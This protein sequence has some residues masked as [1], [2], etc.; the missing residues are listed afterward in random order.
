[1]NTNSRRWM[2]AGI[3]ILAAIVLVIGTI[4]ISRVFFS[5]TAAMSWGPGRRFGLPVTG[6]FESNGERI[7]FTGTSSTGPAISAQFPG[8]HSMP[9]GRTACAECH[10][11]QGQGGVVRWMMTTF[12]APDIRYST[13][14]A[15]DHGNGHGDHPEYTDETLKRAITGGVDPSGEPLEWMMPRWNMT[16]DQ[17]NDLIAFLQTLH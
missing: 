8:M 10:G 4:L 7:F 11:R 3:L 17:L 5:S 16:D 6:N 1:M 14:T 15:E 2:A 9:S 12:E 13:L